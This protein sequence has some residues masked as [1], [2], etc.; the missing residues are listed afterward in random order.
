[1]FGLVAAL[2]IA[3]G[4]IRIL[5]ATMERFPFVVSDARAGWTNRPNIEQQPVVFGNSRFI[6]ST[7]GGGR[8]ITRATGAR[9]TASAA[10]VVLLGD[11]FVY[12]LGV[13]DEETV[14]S[15]LARETRYGIVNLGVVGYGTD[16]ELVKLEEFLGAAAAT[17]APVEAIIVFVFDNDFVDVQRESDPYLGRTKPR[18]YAQGELVRAPYALRASD[19]LMDLSQ[20]FWVV[21]SKRSTLFAGVDP[22]PRDGIAIVVGC[23]QAMRRLAQ[24]NGARFHVLLHHRLTNGRVRSAPI[25]DDAIWERFIQQT[26]ALDITNDI[27]GGDGADPIGLD[28]GHWSAAGHR[29]VAS[30]ILADILEVS[31]KR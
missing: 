28:G 27:L 6:M 19:R 31:D 12:G 4:G 2:G 25:L 17:K 23:L 29:R 7:D 8:R 5:A 16:Q 18:F 3:E 20:L 30:K 26:G 11:S 24:A 15:I 13:N 9:P 21:N 10:Q 22:A 14:G 1:L